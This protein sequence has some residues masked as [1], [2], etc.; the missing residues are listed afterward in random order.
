LRQSSSNSTV[1]LSVETHRRKRVCLTV[2]REVEKE[3]APVAGLEAVGTENDVILSYRNDPRR[4][5]LDLAIQPL[6]K[7]Y[8]LVK[9]STQQG[10]NL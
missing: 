6:A 7:G 9:K 1:C 2:E 8:L 10:G 3:T 5:W 4:F